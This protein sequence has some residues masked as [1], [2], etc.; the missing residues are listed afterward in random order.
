M[1]KFM[2]K[3][4]IIDAVQFTGEWTDEIKA[5]LCCPYS[6]DPDENVI[7]IQTLE[8]I[9]LARPG[10]WL[11]KGI[12]E[13]FYPCKPDIFQKTYTPCPIGP[14]EIRSNDC[15]DRVEIIIWNKDRTALENSIVVNG[16]ELIGAIDSA[17][18]NGSMW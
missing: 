13:E 10:D 14:L 15:D 11:I 1:S 9:M 3:P 4:V 17:L 12:N 5:F 8:G 16:K 2:K 18:L 7:R 6:F